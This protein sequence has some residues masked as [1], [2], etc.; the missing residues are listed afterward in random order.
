MPILIFL[1]LTACSNDDPPTSSIPKYGEGVYILN[2]GNFGGGTG[3]V[4]Y[5]NGDSI[6]QNIFQNNNFGKNL[7]NVAQSMISVFDKF[8]LSINN[9]GKVV[10]ADDQSFAE[11]SEIQGLAQPRSFYNYNDQILFL[12]EWGS[13]GISGK[14]HAIDLMTDEISKTVNTN[15]GPEGMAEVDDVLYVAK[16]GGF[17]TDSLLLAYDIADQEITNSYVVGDNPINVIADRIGTLWIL[18]TGAFDFSNPANNT[19]GT[20]VQF[21]NGQILQSIS[22]DNGVSDLAMD[23]SED[24]LY[25]LAPGRIM[26]FD[27]ALGTQPEVFKEGFFYSLSVDPE[28]GDVYAADAKDFSSL[29]EVVVYDKMGAEKDRISVGIIPGQVYFKD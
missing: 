8:Y 25:F 22:V 6:E 24:Y 15:G 2:E 1:F 9:G 4:T 26:K 5:Y 17:G 19:P 20:L 21:D 14:I 18:C 10:V 23:M 27:M 28:N 3:T 16:S 11:L 12:T 13:D 29:G 7:G